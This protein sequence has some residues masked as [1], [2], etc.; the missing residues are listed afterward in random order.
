[1]RNYTG[2]QEGQTCTGTAMLACTSLRTMRTATLLLPIRAVHLVRPRNGVPQRA[3]SGSANSG[4]NRSGGWNK[5]SAYRGWAR[6]AA[7][8]A[9]AAGGVVFL[10]MFK[11]TREGVSPDPA[12]VNLARASETVQQ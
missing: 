10:P 12:P 4:R 6:V 3:L 5:E 7:G 2:A 11:E 8:V 1:M 9:V